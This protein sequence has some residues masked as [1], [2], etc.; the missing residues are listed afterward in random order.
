MSLYLSIPRLARSLVLG[1]MLSCTHGIEQ[2]TSQQVL[3]QVT[4]TGIFDAQEDTR[5]WIVFIGRSGFT[6]AT[7]QL[8]TNGSFQLTLK[9]LLPGNY[10]FYFGKKSKRTKNYR[11]FQIPVYKKNINLGWI[12]PG[13]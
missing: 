7:T 4:I 11:S 9:N 8:K 2:S 6:S 13:I 5:N 10:Q 12:K 3:G 1:L